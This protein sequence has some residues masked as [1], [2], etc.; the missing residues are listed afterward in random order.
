MEAPV[1]VTKQVLADKNDQESR[2]KELQTQQQ[3]DKAYM[4]GLQDQIKEQEFAIGCLE[5]ARDEKEQERDAE[6]RETETLRHRVRES[7]EH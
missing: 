1:C 7:R 2:N 4:R 5:K 6:R 3:K